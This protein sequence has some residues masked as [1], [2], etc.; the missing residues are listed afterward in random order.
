M[1]ANELTSHGI[2]GQ[3]WRRHTPTE[4]GHVIGTGKPGTGGQKTNKP[5]E[6]KESAQTLPGK[7]LNGL[8]NQA[9]RNVK[10]GGTSMVPLPCKT[11][12]VTR[13]TFQHCPVLHLSKRSIIFHSLPA[14]VN[15]PRRLE[16]LSFVDVFS[17]IC[18]N[19]A[20]P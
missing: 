10:K 16:S 9:A 20:P 11:S 4:L 19:P 7:H 5:A 18:S 8:S 14:F 15:R 13:A 17:L 3:K 12:C 1:S 2:L 6:S